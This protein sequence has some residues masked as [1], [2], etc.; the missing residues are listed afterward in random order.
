MA[1]EGEAETRWCVTA[2]NDKGGILTRTGKDLASPECSSRLATGALVREVELSGERLSF[3]KITGEGPEKG[4]VST[5]LKDKVL[6]EL[7]PV[8]EPQEAEA[9]RAKAVFVDPAPPAPE[10][11]KIRILVLHGTCSNEKITR[12]QLV[13]LCKLTKEDIEWVFVEGP[14]ECDEKNPIVGKQVVTMQKF[15][16]GQ[17]F[18]QWVEPL[19]E[20]L[21]WRKYD[22]IDAAIETIQTGLKDLAPIDAILGFSQ[23]SNM[24]HITAAQAVLGKGAPLRCVVHIG[25]SKPGWTAQMPDLFEYKNPLPALIVRAELDVLTNGSDDIAASYEKPDRASHP[26]EHRPLPR[27]K[28]KAEELAEVIKS[29]L[30]RHCR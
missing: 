8:Y 18:S 23:G 1:K 16:P 30:I 5:R 14:R 20:Q 13:H 6:M 22:G 3:E 2:T 11:R 19:G 29:Y 7:A 9:G 26:D 12:A 25:T 15:Y 10:S 21:G 17:T 24:A 4:W 27:D 28:A